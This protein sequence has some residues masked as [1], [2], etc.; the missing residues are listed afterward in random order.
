MHH[1]TL[2]T[3]AYMTL[4]VCLKKLKIFLIEVLQ[5][6]IS[7]WTVWWM[8]GSS[9]QE[10]KLQHAWQSASVLLPL[11]SSKQLWKEKGQHSIHA[12][13]LGIPCVVRGFVMTAM[14]PWCA[15]DCYKTSK[16]IGHYLASI[17]IFTIIWM[18][19]TGKCFQ[20]NST[21]KIFKRRGLIYFQASC[22][23][24]VT[25]ISLRKAVH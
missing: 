4:C 18:W 25:T 20:R 15:I 22:E 14:K 9:G 1:W 19:D 6:K 12:I 7:I 5:C 24:R 21:G 13:T 17:S 3:F 11:P 10:G 2:Y 23:M 16:T 8:K